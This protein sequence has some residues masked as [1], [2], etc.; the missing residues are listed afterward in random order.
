MAG[1]PAEFQIWST[2][3]R[4]TFKRVIK[5]L[6]DAVATAIIPCVISPPWPVSVSL[7]S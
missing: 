1:Y 4:L 7:P 2:R 6:G 3:C 5:R